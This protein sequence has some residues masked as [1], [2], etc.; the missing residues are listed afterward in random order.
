MAE[1]TSEAE[2]EDEDDDDYD[3]EPVRKHPIG[4]LHRGHDIIFHNIATAQ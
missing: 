1:S 2:E 4:R 3:E